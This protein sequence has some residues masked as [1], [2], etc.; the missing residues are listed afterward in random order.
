M[1]KELRGES[2]RKTDFITSNFPFQV[3]PTGLAAEDGRLHCGDVIK[4][5]S[6]GEYVY[7]M[8]QL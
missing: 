1:I 7:T 5:V 3:L 8:H 4:R 6:T 2:L